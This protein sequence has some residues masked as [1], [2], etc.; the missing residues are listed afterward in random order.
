MAGCSPV[1]LRGTS[2]TKTPRLGRFTQGFTKLIFS[3]LALTYCSEKLR[4]FSEVVR[5][6]VRRSGPRNCLCLKWT[7]EF[8]VRQSEFR[9][10][11][12]RVMGFIFLGLETFFPKIPFRASGK[13]KSSHA[14][15]RSFSRGGGDVD[16][17]TAA[18]VQRLRPRLDETERFA[19]PF[20]V[21]RCG[22]KTKQS[23]RL[24]RGCADYTES[25][26]D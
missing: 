14:C 16:D 13:R 23:R 25:S 9:R 5:P 1:A 2:T 10:R 3:R 20:A 22:A 21:V 12:D 8:A 7:M 26:A 17:R 18:V 6:S 4:R 19:E 15:V 11:L 24:I